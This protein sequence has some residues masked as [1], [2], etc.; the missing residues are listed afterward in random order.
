MIWLIPVALVGLGVAAWWASD[1]EK[2]AKNRLDRDYERMNRELDRHNRDLSMHIQKRQSAIALQQL[3]QSY[4]TSIR[5]ADLAYTLFQDAKTSLET[6]SRMVRQLKA[7]K[8]QLKN[9]LSTAIGQIK[10]ELHEQI[11]AV[12]A[13]LTPLYEQLDV[14][15]HQKEQLYQKLR[16]LN[17]KTGQIRHQLGR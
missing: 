10:R 7:T 8:N 14:V 5:A 11:K 2:E 16:Q 17:M 4:H 3:K 12:N 13:L 6:V 15:K 9:Q 1:D